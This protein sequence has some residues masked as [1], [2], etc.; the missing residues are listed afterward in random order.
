LGLVFCEDVIRFPLKGDHMR[1]LGTAYA[2]PYAPALAILEDPDDPRHCV[3]S[4]GWSVGETLGCRLHDL[5]VRWER[6]WSIA[7]VL[8]PRLPTHHVGEIREGETVGSGEGLRDFTVEIGLSPETWSQT[9]VLG[10][11]VLLAE[12]GVLALERLAARQGWTGPAGAYKEAVRAF[13]RDE[14]DVP[15]VAGTR[16]DGVDLPRDLYR[17]LTLETWTGL[18]DAR[19]NELVDAVTEALHA[20]GRPLE[21]MGIRRFGPMRDPLPVARWRDPETGVPFSLIGGGRFR[22]G[23]TREQ[24][25]RLHREH[26]K[27]EGDEEIDVDF[28][29]EGDEDDPAPR[30]NLRPDRTA[31]MIHPYGSELPCD[32]GRKRPATIPPLLL[33]A[34]PLLWGAP[35]L[36]ELLDLSRVRLYDSPADGPRPNQDVLPID[37]RWFEVAPLLRRY[38]WSLPASAEYE[39]ALRGGLDSL[40]Y[41]GDEPPDVAPAGVTNGH[42]FEAERPRAWPWCNRFGLAA[43]LAISLWCLPLE[44]PDEA[45]PLVDRG[46]TDSCWPGQDCGEWWLFASAVD[47]RRS[48]DSD[49]VPGAALRP[50]IRLRA[51]GR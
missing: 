32:I 43:P 39:W 6:A 31:R 34:E 27:S 5:G 30:V 40:F 48:L 7:L 29:Y 42:S 25:R 26:E 17:S 44:G 4:F 24:L 12:L 8:T 16:A 21:P 45:F 15:W 9:P 11:R 38:N 18:D 14:A 37:L 49:M 46:G 50:V 23:Y 10:K 3:D 2:D 51:R 1:M 13:R 20:A 33:A 41:W 19:R 36:R 47:C 35:G 28:F 22:P